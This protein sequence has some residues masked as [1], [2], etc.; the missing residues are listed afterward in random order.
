[1]TKEGRKP[2]DESRMDDSPVTPCRFVIGP[3]SLFRHSAFVIR[4]WAVALLAVLVLT[5]CSDSS[6]PAPPQPLILYTSVDEPYVRP[7]LAEFESRT[8]IRVT[9]QTDT[10][11]TKSAG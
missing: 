5:S 2:N 7:I 10:E 9:V 11:A 1:M 6:A 8:G 4:H 3:S